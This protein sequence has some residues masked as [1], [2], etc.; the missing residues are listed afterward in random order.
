MPRTRTIA[1]RAPSAPTAAEIVA[2]QRAELA[3][4]SDRLRALRLQ[5]ERLEK[6]EATVDPVDP[7]RW[8]HGAR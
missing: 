5:K 1:V 2:D 4:K 8:T 7:P 6:G 3:A